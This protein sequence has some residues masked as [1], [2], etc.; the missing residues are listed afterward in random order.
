MGFSAEGTWPIMKA[1]IEE[2]IVEETED[3]PN[4]SP[5]GKGFLTA[6]KVIASLVHIFGYITIRNKRIIGKNYIFRTKSFFSYVGSF[7]QSYEL[8]TATV[9]TP[10]C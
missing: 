6:L 1:K 9:C 10:Y 3:P 7:L 4:S 2:L 5:A 8:L